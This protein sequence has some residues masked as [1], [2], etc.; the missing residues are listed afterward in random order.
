MSALV[1]PTWWSAPSRK[2]SAAISAGVWLVDLASKFTPSDP[3]A[4]PPAPP[5]AFSCAR[6]AWLRC[7]NSARWPS[8]ISRC[9][10]ITA[11]TPL[12]TGPTPA[13]AVPSAWCRM[14]S[15]EPIVSLS[16]SSLSSI[17]FTPLRLLGSAS[18]T[19]L[20]GSTSS[21]S[22]KP[23]RFSTLLN[24]LRFTSPSAPHVSAASNSFTGGMPRLTRSFER[25]RSLFC[26]KAGRPEISSRLSTARN[27]S[28]ETRPA[29]AV[30]MNLKRLTKSMG[31]RS[32]CVFSMRCTNCSSSTPSSSRM[33]TL[34]IS[35]GERPSLSVIS[36]QN[37]RRASIL[38]STCG[39]GSMNRQ[40]AL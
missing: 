26:S 8:N 29:P 3:P 7:W 23:I 18:T 27:W 1:V 40:K 6:A 21:T 15:S 5:A 19:S 39:G 34:K 38:R 37:L 30:S 28:R 14:L 36:P 31:S 20:M 16:T 10:R 33:S 32:R 4:A 17:T 2:G 9:W 12:E 22:A 11:S 24:S 13:P 35:R 25:S